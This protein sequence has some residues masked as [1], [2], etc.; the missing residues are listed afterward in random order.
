MSD[1]AALF[2]LRIDLDAIAQDEW[3]EIGEPWREWLIPADLPN[4][5]TSTF[6]ERPKM[7]GPEAE[8]RLLFR[9]TFR[10]E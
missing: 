2:A 8:V 9:A 5:T 3:V 6:G 7:R 4:K 1:A 10:G